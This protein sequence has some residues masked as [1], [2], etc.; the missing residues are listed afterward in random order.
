MISPLVGADND[1]Y[2]LHQN[3]A[4]IATDLRAKIHAYAG[5]FEKILPIRGKLFNP[6]L[7]QLEQVRPEQNDQ[8]AT[9]R[10][11]LLTTIFGVRYKGIGKD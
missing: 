5:T 7:H 6:N 2:R 10:P 8:D 11:I 1:I 4:G 3:I 9:G